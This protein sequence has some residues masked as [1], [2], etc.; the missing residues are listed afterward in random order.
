M[1]SSIITLLLLAF[2]NLVFGQ[3]YVGNQADIDQILENVDKFSAYV[4]AS[5]YKG[6]GECYTEDAK[7]F[8]SNIEIVA[9]QDSI[10]EYWV[11]PEGVSIS[12]HKITPI[13][14]KIIGDEAYDYGYYEGMTV[15]ANGDQIGWRGKYVII[16]KKIE[17]DWKIY[18]DIWNSIRG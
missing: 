8:P 11:L 6:I 18:L 17:G 2:S 9:G 16:W 5:D 13:E 4:V 10:I 1:K 7:I 15:R 12:R 3:T 14:I